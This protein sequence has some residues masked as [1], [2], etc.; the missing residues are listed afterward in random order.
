M[1]NH[2]QGVSE[3]DHRARR[4]ASRALSRSRAVLESGCDALPL[5][6]LWQ[7]EEIVVPDTVGVGTDIIAVG[8]LRDAN[9]GP[10]AVY[11]RVES[12]GLVVDRG[13]DLLPGPFPAAAAEMRDALMRVVA[14]LLV[15]AGYLNVRGGRA[16]LLWTG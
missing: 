4:C 13:D 10:F 16:D 5:A 7:R 12:V 2:P 15:D 8:T 14:R 1:T 9:I 6:T 3:G 11:P